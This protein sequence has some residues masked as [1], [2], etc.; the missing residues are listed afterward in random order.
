MQNWRFKRACFVCL[1]TKN[2]LLNYKHDVFKRARGHK[3]QTTVD[4]SA[5]VNLQNIRH[6][7]DLSESNLL[8]AL[9][10]QI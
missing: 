8:A 6:E 1:Q 7:S 9:I 3:S 5:D 10:R 4:A 2:L